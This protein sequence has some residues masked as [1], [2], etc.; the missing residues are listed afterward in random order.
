MKRAGAF[1]SRSFV[2][3]CPCAFLYYLL[4]IALDVVKWI[5]FLVSL[6]FLKY[7]KQRPVFSLY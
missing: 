2:F 7:G 4:W 3:L 6:N 5:V 1:C